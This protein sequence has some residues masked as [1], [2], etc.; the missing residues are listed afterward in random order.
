[1][2]KAQFTLIEDA[3]NEGIESFFQDS[4]IEEKIKTSE[5]RWVERILRSTLA[6]SFAH[7]LRYTNDGFDKAKFVTTICNR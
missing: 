7:K 2:T 1:M 5:L 4:R 6:D 3:I